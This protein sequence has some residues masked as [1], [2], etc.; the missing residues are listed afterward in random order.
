MVRLSTLS[1]LAG[2]ALSGCSMVPYYSQLKQ[3]ADTGVATAVEDR[4]EFNDKKLALSL[5]AVC[6]SSVGAVYRLTSAEL[7]EIVI[8]LCGGDAS[9]GAG[10]LSQL[11]K[12]FNPST[13]KIELPVAPDNPLVEPN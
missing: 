5:T 9:I 11:L 2:I 4:K 6:D 7:R 3:V 13:G 12:L 8:R 1:V 10:E